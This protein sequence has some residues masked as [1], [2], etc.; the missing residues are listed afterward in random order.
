MLCARPLLSVCSSLRTFHQCHEWRCAG[1]CGA[2]KWLGAADGTRPLAPARY[3][4]QARHLC[5]SIHVVVCARCYAQ[6]LGTHGSVDCTYGG[7]GAHTLGIAW[8][9]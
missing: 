8:I 2:C 9:C 5:R 3:R 4:L 6:R 1:D 7:H